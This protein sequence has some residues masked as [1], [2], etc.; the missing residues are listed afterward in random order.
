MPLNDITNNTS[1]N[2]IVKRKRLTDYEL[3]TVI[4]HYDSGLMP[5]AI[6]R[7]ASAKPR[8]EPDQKHLVNVRGQIELT[9]VLKEEWLLLAVNYLETLLSS[10]GRRCQ[11]VIEAE[12]S[13]PKY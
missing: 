1:S 13:I 8:F 9:A 2:V 5:A 10:I 11:A 12:G 4:G 3:G 7:L 6:G